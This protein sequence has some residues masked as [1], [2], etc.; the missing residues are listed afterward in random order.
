[1]T[2]EFFNSM[3]AMY[4]MLCFAVYILFDGLIRAFKK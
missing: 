3:I 2:W 1:M 4:L